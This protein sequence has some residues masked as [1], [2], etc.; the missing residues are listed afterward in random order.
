MDKDWNMKCPLSGKC[1]PFSQE[2][3]QEYYARLSAKEYN[4]QYEEKDTWTIT[5]IYPSRNGA[6]VYFSTSSGHTRYMTISNFYDAINTHDIVDK[7]LTA[8]FRFKKQGS[9]ITAYVV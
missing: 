1:L 5:D 2:G 9:V 8:T 4:F 3:H 7:Q 6:L